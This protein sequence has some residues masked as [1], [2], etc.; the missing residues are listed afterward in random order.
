MIKR[1]QG[2]EDVPLLLSID[3]KK[4]KK[5]PR[6]VQSE[7]LLLS[8]DCTLQF[9][10]LLADLNYGKVDYHYSGINSR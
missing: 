5:R 1:K 2:K 9:H 7:F 6:D 10:D 4:K 3:Q 8:S